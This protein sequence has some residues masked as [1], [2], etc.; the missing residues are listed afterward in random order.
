MSN[1]KAKTSLHEAIISG[2]DCTLGGSRVAYLSGPITTGLRHVQSLRGR[3]SDHAAPVR[4]ANIEDLVST[5]KLLRTQRSEIII[6]PASLDLP[7]WSQE[8]YHRLWEELIRR[9][10]HLVIF[11]PGWEYSFGSALEFS[12]ASAHGIRT[13]ALSGAAISI[14]EGEALL[15]AARDD[16]RRD[17]ANGAL[18]KLG[19][20]LDLVIKRLVELRRPAKSFARNLPKDESLHVLAE[21][22][23]N[24][25]QFVSFRPANGTPHQAYARVTGRQANEIFA[26]VRSAIESLLKAS[27]SRSINVRSYQPHNS[28]S[29]EFL[30]GLTGVEAAAAAVER[31]SGEGLHTIVNETIDVKD[32]GV[33][34]VLMG[35]VLEFAPDDTPRCV[36]KPGTASLPRGL[37]RELL[38]SVYGFPI[39]F[40]VPF[41][42]RLEFSVHPQP[43]GWRGT[44]ILTWE[45]SEQEQNLAD[46]QMIWPNNFSRLIGDK[47]FGLLVAHHLGLRVPLTTV[48]NR[49]VAAFSF[50]QPTGWGEYWIRTAPPEQAPGLFTTLRGWTDP[51]VLLQAEDPGGKAIASVL[52]Q[53]G[54]LPAYSGALIVGADGGIIVEGRA[55][56]G[57][58]LMLGQR[59]PEQL[60]A[61]IVRDVLSLYKQAT[62]ALGAV[63]F[64]W[65]HDGRQSWIVQLHRGATE[66]TLM[67]LTSGEAKDWV[68]FDV[69]TGLAELRAL[70][71]RFPRD[72][73][74]IL[75]G[76]VGLT[77]HVADVVRKARI[78]AR[79]T[80]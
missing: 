47:T 71:A 14:L 76:Q 74:L 69:G 11:M 36:E 49:R 17:S 38:A 56:T 77:S 25:A 58:S 4:Q 20:Q 54:V 42:S 41:A 15:R 7:E 27:A 5:A 73:G 39:E 50:G 48:V 10:V 2:W 3:V 44:N 63:R 68:E 29:R 21:Q 80:G 51:F 62:A 43:Q 37:G 33:S 12:H 64:E 16:L 57:D 70:L 19:S 23:M 8:D 61:K 31:L 30:Y 22:G 75:K 28:Q 53:A 79:M 34:G 35:N 45:L 60:P 78:P 26:N 1:T 32:G 66:T 40:P 65:V 24:V 18:A 46:P 52:S 67:R 9:H 59:G 13:E 55:G 6:E 72:T